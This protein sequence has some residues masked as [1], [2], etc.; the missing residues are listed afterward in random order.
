M[1][2]RGRMYG[3]PPSTNLDGTVNYRGYIETWSNAYILL[4]LLLCLRISNC[5]CDTVL[6]IKK[7]NRT[8]RRQNVV[9]NIFEIV[10]DNVMLRQR[11]WNFI[12]TEVNFK[13]ETKIVLRE[14]KNRGR[15]LFYQINIIYRPYFDVVNSINKRIR[16]FIIADRTFLNKNNL[17]IFSF[18]FFF[19]SNFEIRMELL[20]FDSSL[21]IYQ[22]TKFEHNF[23][24]LK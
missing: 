21:T 5:V 11:H 23:F 13:R 6:S 8:T 17:L 2:T 16:R 4:L 24:T 20:S 22:L 10:Y 14:I 9:K 1:S 19:Y 7:M 18:E 12:G 15:F 3:R